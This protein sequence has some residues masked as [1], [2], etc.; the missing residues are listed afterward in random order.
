MRTMTILT[1]ICV[2]STIVCAARPVLFYG[3]QDIEKLKS[4]TALPEY[5]G[6]W[7]QI[8]EDAD[9]FCDPDSSR[10]AEPG[11]FAASVEVETGKRGRS[12]GGR[13]AHW[14]GRNLT[15]WLETLGFAYQITGEEKYGK[16]GAALLVE[17]A[18]YITVD[19]PVI[20]EAFAGARG[21]M[22]RAFATGL[23][24]LSDAITAQQRRSVVLTARDY[25]LFNIKEYN[26]GD[27]WWG[28]YH[29]FKGVCG[30]SSGM[31]AIA[32]REDYPR[33]VNRWVMHS[34]KMVVDYLAESL[35]EKGA[36][37]EGVMY[38]TYGLQNV[39]LFGDAILRYKNDSDI[40]ANPRL[41]NVPYYLAMNMLPGENTFDARNESLFKDDFSKPGI[42]AAMMLRLAKGVEGEVDQN[43][44][45]AWLWEQIGSSY[46]KFL[47]IA[48]G[49]NPSPQKPEKFIEE[50][51]GVHFEKNGLCVWRS[52]W[53]KDDVMFSVEAGEYNEISH[54]QADEG[55]FNL[56]GLG[57]RWA[58]DT[59]AGKN[60]NPEGRCQTLAHSCVLVNGRGQA[61]SSCARGTS[62]KILKYENKS[63][64]GYAM[65]DA[66]S[67]YNTNDI[68]QVGVP[69]SKALRHTIFIRPADG[70]PAYAVVL[71]DIEWDE[72]ICEFTWQ[73]M[74]WQDM[75]ITFAENIA[76]V[77]PGD[78]DTK[79][80]MEVFIDAANPV[81]L[82]YDKYAPDDNHVPRDF[83]RLRAKT[84][85]V[86]P[87]FVAVLVPMP[88]DQKAP[89]INTRRDGREVYIE[90]VWTNR[91]DRIKWSDESVSIE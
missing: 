4:R 28:K 5:S 13:A 18:Q 8:L 65:T 26:G 62:G 37:L 61:L 7:R 24:M 83:L 33:E 52:G 11:E 87:R 19:N 2:F 55:H 31:L 56:Y 35:D 15:E 57:Y 81:K 48:W 16:H 77:S 53:S 63:R 21:D 43:P 86:N 71:D 67:A 73:M 51:F 29:N 27:V 91:T 74:T 1:T 38:S 84:D 59:A 6:V 90:I 58:T 40:L 3:E 89:K 68:G 49:P 14:Y 23:D 12:I 64:Y 60:L 76:T 22:M 32:L 44:L 34:K 72:K 78:L 88:A 36:A 79:P 42:G 80:R 17:S 45:A 10:Y 50:P 9:A 82:S 47:H 66:K 69:V 46:Q 75:N 85:A 41:N 25:V 39:V 30:G 20:S 70:V 54:D